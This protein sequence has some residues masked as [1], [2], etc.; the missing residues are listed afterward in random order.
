MRR[1]HGGTAQVA[2]ADQ[3]ETEPER[4]AAERAFDA[5][6]EMTKT[7]IAAI[8]AAFGRASEVMNRRLAR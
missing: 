1:L 7:G 3:A 4:A 5:M 6:L 2:T 8:E